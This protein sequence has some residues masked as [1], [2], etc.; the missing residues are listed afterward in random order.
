MATPEP[1]IRKTNPREQ[2]LWTDL[3][4][5]SSQDNPTAR[6]SEL[7]AKQDTI[8]VLRVFSLLLD[9]VTKKGHPELEVNANI[10]RQL[11]KQDI[12]VKLG[13]GLSIPAVENIRLEVTDD[14][15]KAKLKKGRDEKVGDKVVHVEYKYTKDKDKIFLEKYDAINFLLG[16]IWSDLK[17]LAINDQNKTQVIQLQAIA[18]IL[19]KVEIP[20]WL[21]PILNKLLDIDIG[22]MAQNASGLATSLQS[23]LAQY[24]QHLTEER[25]AKSKP[26]PS[27]IKQTQPEVKTPETTPPTQSTTQKT[28]SDEMKLLQSQLTPLS[29]PPETKLSLKAQ[30]LDELEQEQKNL[31]GRLVELKKERDKLKLSQKTLTTIL[32]TSQSTIKELRDSKAKAET[33]IKELEAKKTDLTNLQKELV[34]NKR[35]LPFDETIAIQLG[36]SKDEKKQWQDNSNDQQ[37]WGSY[38]TSTAKGFFSTIYSSWQPDYKSQYYTNIDSLTKALTGIS[39]DVAQKITEQTTALNQLAESLKTTLEKE[40]EFAKGI[41]K[42]STQLSQLEQ[43]E[44][45]INGSLIK[46]QAQIETERKNLEERKKAL[47]LA[48]QSQPK[49]ESTPPPVTP[50]LP[51]KEVKTAPETLSA[52]PPSPIRDTE[53][54]EI[55]N[56]LDSVKTQLEDYTNRWHIIRGLLKWLASFFDNPNMFQD[57]KT[58]FKRHELAKQLNTQLNDLTPD[59]NIETLRSTITAAMKTIIEMRPQLEVKGKTTAGGSKLSGIISHI[60]GAKQIL[61]SNATQPTPPKIKPS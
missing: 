18:S 2:K 31:S 32:E 10:L 1:D 33:V 13:W 3:Q 38:L 45:A 39:T 36:L 60:E 61:E 47:E 25:T 44:T 11:T 9:E 12:G 57:T 19:S 55:R 6:L 49:P 59:T 8:P 40:Q 21:S 4:T 20:G 28:Q 54:S 15:V 23:G 29:V 46:I 27:E 50:Q 52:P 41:E 53:I 5:R 58:H 16:E 48:R 35:V 30:S 17:K 26:T 56:Q 7:L 14:E 43:N 22:K 24:E 51:H 42:A 37:Y 34:D